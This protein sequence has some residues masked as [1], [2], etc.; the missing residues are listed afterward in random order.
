MVRRLTA[1]GHEVRVLVRRVE[2]V[3]SLAL[4]GVV[5]T[6][7]PAVAVDGVQTCVVCLFD[8]AQVRAALAGPLSAALP[9]D[10]VVVV[11]TTGSPEVVERLAGRGIRVLDAPVSGGPHDIAAGRITVFAGGAADDLDR[12]RPALAAYA[13][14]LLHV[15]PLGAGQRV[16]L[17][18]NAL[19][20]AQVGLLDEAVRLAAA[21][22]VTEASLLPALRHGSSGGPAVE[23][24]AAHGSVDAFAR[25]AGAFLRKDV[26]AVREVASGLDARLG[27][28]APM[29]DR[30]AA[31]AV[32]ARAAGR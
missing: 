14:P 8:E 29:L 22:G 19:F 16:K 32:R 4:E 11:H 20:A 26:I 23:R 15:G 25:A 13:D 3:E 27:E 9:G 7:D 21:F 2:A 10:A 18:N 31:L 1:A 17:V 5:A 6:R 24:A 12:V 28:V 30:L